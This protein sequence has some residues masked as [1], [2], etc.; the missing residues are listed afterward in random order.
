MRQRPY[1]GAPEVP[2]DVP[3]EFAD[4][5]LRGYA[6]A[7]EEAS[8]LATTAAPGD[9]VDVPELPPSLTG[10]VIPE[11]GPALP[12]PRQPAPRASARRSFPSPRPGSTTR[13]A[14]PAAAPAVAPAPAQ[15][16]A[17]A[18][19]TVPGA[20]LDGPTLEAPAVVP[21]APRVEPAVADDVVVEP[22]PSIEVEQPAEP[23]EPER[24]PR[25]ASSE[26]FVPWAFEPPGVGEQDAPRRWQFEPP[27]EPTAN[28]A[29]EILEAE[30]R[31]PGAGWTFE[32]P[33][34]QLVDEAPSAIDV[35][36]DTGRD[37]DTVTDLE[38]VEAPVAREQRDD[39]VPGMRTYYRTDGAVYADA[40]TTAT[41]AE[42]PP[43]MIPMMTM[44]LIAALFLAVYALAR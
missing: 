35:L 27:E 28:V 16:E 9:A 11:E 30:E 4:A 2:P 29:L 23:L 13:S 43:W 1:L 44:S 40:D 41:M 18:E 25:P 5:Y 33:V 36:M 12:A 39:L 21:E 6:R 3:P 8:T 24:S 7:R 31:V 20:V 38:P 37:A 32:P 19:A 42:A 26:P 14:A 10:F 17:P 15:V 22:V 34:V